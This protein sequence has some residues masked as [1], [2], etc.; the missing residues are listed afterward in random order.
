PFG[1]LLAL[2]TQDRRAGLLEPVTNVAGKRL[3]LPVRIGGGDDHRIGEAGELADIE[4]ND[5]ARLDVVESSD[6]GLLDLVK[7]HP[8]VSDRVGCGQYR[9][10]PRPEANC[11]LP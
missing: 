10:K 5:V 3:H 7:S 2:D 8:G 6:G 11:A 4:D 9:P 1:G